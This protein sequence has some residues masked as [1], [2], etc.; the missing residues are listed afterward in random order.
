MLSSWIP[1]PSSGDD[2]ENIPVTRNEKRTRRNALI[3]GQS[4]THPTTILRVRLMSR[5]NTQGRSDRC[6]SVLSRAQL[7]RLWPSLIL[8]LV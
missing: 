5:P 2:K 1:F 7:R 8:V 6:F 4:A 3:D